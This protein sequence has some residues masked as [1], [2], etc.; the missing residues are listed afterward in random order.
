VDFV[1]AGVGIGALL[2]VISFAIRD[3]APL[4]ARSRGPAEDNARPETRRLAWL[5]RVATGIAICGGMIIAA[6]AVAIAA[7]QSDSTG[8]WIV[9]GSAFAGIALAAGYIVRT[10]RSGRETASPTSQKPDPLPEPRKS[11]PLSNLGAT[12]PTVRRMPKVVSATAADVSGESSDVYEAESFDPFDPTKLLAEEFGEMIEPAANVVPQTVDAA[13]LSPAAESLPAFDGKS[14]AA[15]REETEVETEHP[16]ELEL[17][18]LFPAS[19]TETN[20]SGFQSPVLAGIEVDEKDEG[21]VG[22]FA[23]HLLADVAPEEADQES[24]Q[25]PL[26][27]DVAASALTE[28]TPIAEQGKPPASI[29]GGSEEITPPGEITEESTDEDMAV[30]ERPSERA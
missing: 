14:D 2:V 7:N 20:T 26:L 11:R 1:V 27:A 23:S 13:D 19:T 10:S 4:L 28:Y 8:K 15:E 9:L 5:N 22:Q 25:S 21:T 6:T 12:I 17:I 24:F 30:G 18:S 29:N 3:A 16:A